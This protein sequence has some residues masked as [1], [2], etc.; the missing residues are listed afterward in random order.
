MPALRLTLKA[1]SDLTR[2]ETV[3]ALEAVLA[4]NHIEMVPEGDRDVRAVLVPG[5][6]PNEPLN[7]TR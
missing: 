5:T 2:R 3:Y 7:R 1:Y 4:L 6:K